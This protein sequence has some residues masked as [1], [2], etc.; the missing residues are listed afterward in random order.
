M[1]FKQNKNFFYPDGVH[2]NR[3]SHK[4]LFDFIKDKILTVQ[5]IQK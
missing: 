5:N 3:I 1:L 2:A 4:I